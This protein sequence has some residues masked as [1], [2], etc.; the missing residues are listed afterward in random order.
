MIDPNERDDGVG[1]EGKGMR[2]VGV[3][4]NPAL[5]S[6]RGLLGG[7]MEMRREILPQE[8][9]LSP[10]TEVV[11]PKDQWRVWYKGKR[12]GRVGP[13]VEDVVGLVDE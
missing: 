1:P 13:S 4:W 10:G 3:W 9:G 12:L 6:T 2:V 5:S 7:T 11:P 8:T